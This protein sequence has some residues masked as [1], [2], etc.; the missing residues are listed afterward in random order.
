MAC[1][2]TATACL[3]A[4][5]FRLT[6]VTLTRRDDGLWDV[7]RE[8]GDTGERITGCAS[9]VEAGR[10]ARAGLRLLHGRTA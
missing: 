10:S 6:K 7:L 9:L 4:G 5:I 8:H 2:K 3:Q 1:G